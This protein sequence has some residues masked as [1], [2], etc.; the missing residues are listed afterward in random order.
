MG[1]FLHQNRSFKDLLCQL[2]RQIF[3]L[4]LTRNQLKIF[5]FFK[6]NFHLYKSIF[7]LTSI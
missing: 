1:K 5:H 4:Y 2:N 7:L 6:K 3:I